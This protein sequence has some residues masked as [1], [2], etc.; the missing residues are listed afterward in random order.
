MSGDSLELL[1]LAFVWIAPIL[2]VVLLPGRILYERACKR[3]RHC[4][5]GPRWAFVLGW[6][7]T[8]FGPCLLMV[9]LERTDFVDYPDGG[10]AFVWLVLGLLTL[11]VGA[12]LLV[13]SS[14]PR[15]E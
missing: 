11:F 2:T 12:G 8:A 13:G 4:R 7:F 3:T 15:S 1:W 14:I 10:H 9:S 5:P 6:F